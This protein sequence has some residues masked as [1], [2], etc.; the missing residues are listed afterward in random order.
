M[1]LRLWPAD[2]V[3]LLYRPQL[4]QELGKWWAQFC[5]SKGDFPSAVHYYN[6]SEDALSLVRRCGLHPSS[7]APPLNALLTPKYHPCA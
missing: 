2:V 4:A 6:I 3:C 1:N 7:P 5:E